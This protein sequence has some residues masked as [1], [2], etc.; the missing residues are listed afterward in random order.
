MFGRKKTE[1]G[2]QALQDSL[3]YVS[4]AIFLGEYPYPV[5]LDTKHLKPIIANSIEKT[6]NSIINL[7]RFVNKEKPQ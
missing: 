5:L 1:M 7:I 3:K 6:L 4:N 2:K